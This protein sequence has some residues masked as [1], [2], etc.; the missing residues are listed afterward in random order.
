MGEGGRRRGLGSVRAEIRVTLYD[1]PKYERDASPAVVTRT[2]GPW[3]M[4]H[5]PRALEFQNLLSKSWAN[6][7]PKVPRLRRDMLAWAAPRHAWVCTFFKQAHN[8]ARFTLQFVCSLPANSGLL[9]QDR[10]RRS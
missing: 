2:M 7:G 4:G 1:D 9:M 8:V 5:G 3:R 6:K 10:L